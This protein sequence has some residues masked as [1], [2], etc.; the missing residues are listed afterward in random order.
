MAEREEPPPP[1]LS[2]LKPEEPVVDG[3][4]LARGAGLSEMLPP[5]ALRDAIV[6]VEYLVHR[7]DYAGA[8]A[9]AAR[10]FNEAARAGATVAGASSGE[11]PA[12]HA[13]ML[14]LPGERYLRFRDTVARAAS[15]GASSADAL[16]T[17]F[18]LVDTALRT[19]G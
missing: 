17:I 10:T 7:G 18:F 3:G 13:L 14:G 11:G 2:P 9:A 5:G 8:V 16:F 12:L 15:G 6:S 1:S 19:K 4:K